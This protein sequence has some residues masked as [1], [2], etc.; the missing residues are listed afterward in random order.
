MVKRVLIGV[1]EKTTAGCVSREEDAERVLFP[2]KELKNN[3]KI[4]LSFEAPSQAVATVVRDVFNGDIP[5]VDTFIRDLC[6][7]YGYRVRK[8]RKCDKLAGVT[9][10][11]RASGSGRSATSP[12]LPCG[13]PR[14]CQVGDSAFGI[15]APASRRPRCA[16]GAGAG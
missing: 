5:D 13:R 3:A 8:Q 16:P 10:L 14:V 2:L 15:T 4:K 7:H 11:S 9:V 1:I 12:S 6:A